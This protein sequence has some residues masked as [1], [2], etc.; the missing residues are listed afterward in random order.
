MI[1]HEDVY[2][3]GRI[4]KPHG[5]GGE[6]SF[7]FDDDVFDRCDAEY[8]VLDIDGILV[9]FFMESYRFSSGTTA[10][11][12]F[13]GIDSQE[14]A[15][16]LTGCAVYFPRNLSDSSDDTVTWSEIIGFTLTDTNSGQSVGTVRSVDS[17]TANLLFE[18]EPPEGG[19]ILI[20]ANEDLIDSFDVERREI[21]MRLPEGLLDLHRL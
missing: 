1:R 13:C 3:I 16:D 5:V 21:K 20:P 17:S 4:G 14:R 15:R 7:M 19:D 9:P 2:R 11:V 18:V 10:L 8:L 6:L 12:K